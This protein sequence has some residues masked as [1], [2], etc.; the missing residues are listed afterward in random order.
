MRSPEVCAEIDD[1]HAKPVRAVLRAWC[2]E[3]ALALTDELNNLREEL[4]RV[5]AIAETA[6][7]A[8][9]E[10]GAARDAARMERDL[11][12]SRPPSRRPTSGEHIG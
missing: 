9:R 6:A 5:S 3:E 12:I 8:L 1:E 4:R 2:G 7:A 10:R 11:G